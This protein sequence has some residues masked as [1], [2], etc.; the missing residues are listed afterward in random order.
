MVISPLYP[1]STK[2][3]DELESNTQ[4]SG[5]IIR[6]DNG[7]R[8]MDVTGDWSPSAS[9]VLARGEVDGLTLNYAR[10]FRERDLEFLQEWPLRRVTILARTISDLE[11]LYRLAGT[12]ENLDLV[13]SDR[14]ALDLSRFP[15]LKHVSCENWSQLK[16]TISACLRLESVYAGSYTSRDLTPLA[17]NRNLLKIRVKDRPHWVKSKWVV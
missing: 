10:G 14:A 11:P 6:S 2:T 7:C 16:P 13:S 9:R 8:T 17:H 5:F 4:G 12:L 15:R 3:G 1:P